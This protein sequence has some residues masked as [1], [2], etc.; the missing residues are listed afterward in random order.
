MVYFQTDYLQVEH[1]HTGNVLI[2]Q[3]YGGCSSLQYR[4]AL[5]N[6]IRIARELQVHCVVLDRRLLK[7]VSEDDLH[8]TCT[9]YAKAYAKLP[10]KKLAVIHS[11]DN[12]TERQQQ[13]LNAHIG[14]YIE[15]R[16]F[17]DLTSAYDWVISVPV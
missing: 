10:L 11:F 14:T 17:D 5:I 8:W 6:V 13:Q 2:T 9:I 1:H 7:P 16:S 12:E 15:T 4:Q 3:W